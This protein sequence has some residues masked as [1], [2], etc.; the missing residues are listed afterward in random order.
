MKRLHSETWSRIELTVI[1]APILF[2]Y[3]VTVWTL[4][5]H[6]VGITLNV[7][8]ALSDIS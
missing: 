8:G 1:A 2:G 7:V 6:L 4:V 3:A 5:S